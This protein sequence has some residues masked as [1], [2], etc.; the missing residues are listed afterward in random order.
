MPGQAAPTSKYRFPWRQGNRLRLLIDGGEFYPRM[1]EAIAGARRYILLE[2][3]LFE[4]GLVASDFITALTSTAARGVRVHL[5]LDDYGAMRLTRRDRQ[6]LTDAGVALAFYNPIRVGRIQRSL[7]RDHRKLLLIDGETAYTGGAGITDEFDPKLYPA[8]HWHELMVEIRGP[9]VLDWQILFKDNWMHWAPDPLHLP[10]APAPQAT[11]G[12]LGR[13]TSSRSPVRSEIARSFVR[14]IRYAERRAWLATAYF[15]PSRKLR[16]A[17]RRAA[18]RGVDVRVMLPGPHTDHGWV[19]TIGRRYYARLLRAGVRIFEYQ[20]R[21]LHVKLALCD[22]WSSVGSSNVDR[23]NLRWNLEANQEVDDSEFAD[24]V[25]AL[26]ERDLHNCRE[27][28]YHQWLRRPWYRR[29]KE[30]SLGYLARALA[31]FSYKKHR[32]SRRDPPL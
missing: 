27:F 16:R 21:F 17:L 18:R 29:L 9:N 19:R 5:L 14:R 24:E 23:W 10:A 4:S 20:P 8:S 3:Y 31:W 12:W 32:P 26:F 25:Q 30:W 7:F 28:H 22:Q 1:L 13:V 11:G 15:A 6:R 2:M